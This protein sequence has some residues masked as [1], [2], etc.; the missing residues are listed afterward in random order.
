LSRPEADAEIEFF[1]AQI[2]QPLGC[3]EAHVDVRVQRAEFVQAWHQPTGRKGSA[4]AD[5][6]CALLLQ[7]R[8]SVDRLG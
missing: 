3:I 6:Q 2:D 7:C 1:A 5:Y 4:A 8:E